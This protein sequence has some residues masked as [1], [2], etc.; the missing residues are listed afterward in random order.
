MLVDSL[1]YLAEGALAELLV[2][3]NHE[4]L[5]ALAL[6]TTPT[7]LITNSWMIGRSLLG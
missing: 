3:V 6:H 2:H 1:V 7:E 5:D 4:V